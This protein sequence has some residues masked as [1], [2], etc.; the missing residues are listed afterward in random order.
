MKKVKQVVKYGIIEVPSRRP[1]KLWLMTYP[2]PL[3]EVASRA[4]GVVLAVALDPPPIAAP[5]V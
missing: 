4:E 2:H 3:A 5:M 1:K